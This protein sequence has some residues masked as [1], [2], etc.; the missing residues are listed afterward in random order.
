MN[1]NDESV[2]ADQQDDQCV[3]DFSLYLIKCVTA[4]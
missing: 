4:Q 1:I 3:V 2:K